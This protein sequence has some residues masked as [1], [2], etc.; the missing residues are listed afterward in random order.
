MK[1]DRAERG[2]DMAVANPA[3]AH[4]RL[5]RLLA[6]V[7]VTSGVTIV[8]ASATPERIA[9]AA[10]LDSSGTP[11]IARTFD[12]DQHGGCTGCQ[13]RQRRVRNGR[14]CLHPAG[15]DHG[16]E[17]L[18]GHR[19]DQRARRHVPDPDPDPERG[20]RHDRRSRHPLA[21]RHR[22][23]GRGSRSSTAACRCPGPTRRREAWTACSRSTP[24]PR[25]SS[26]GT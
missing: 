15:G 10:S 12:V 1:R 17:R 19:P 8:V 5:L 24:P 18:A 21:G 9:Y 11:V 25:T 2:A 4:S 20:R 23:R 13:S 16:G 3:G 6:A 26:S 14:W 7:M 22:R